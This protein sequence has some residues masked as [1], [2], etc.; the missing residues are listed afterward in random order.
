MKQFNR[1]IIYILYVLLS[2]NTNAQTNDNFKKLQELSL[3][4][5]H[6][7]KSKHKEKS[8]DTDDN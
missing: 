8:T 4:N 7:K 3:D 6:Q 2:V 1:F 5:V